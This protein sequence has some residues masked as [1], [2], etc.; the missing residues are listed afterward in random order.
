MKVAYIYGTMT[1]QNRVKKDN[2]IDN[3]FEPVSANGFH[4]LSGLLNNGS[5]PTC[6]SCKHK[7]AML[8][9]RTHNYEL[10]ESVYKCRDCGFLVI[11]D[12]H[13]NRVG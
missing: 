13:G 11:Y 12:I 2:N 4:P 8:Y 6:P 9:D 5:A 10:V 7:N 3:E 1:N